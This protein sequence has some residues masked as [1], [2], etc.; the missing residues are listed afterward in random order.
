LV[1][2][3]RLEKKAIEKMALRA[4]LREVKDDVV[5][6][7][8]RAKFVNV[9]ASLCAKGAEI[10]HNLGLVVEIIKE[11]DVKGTDDAAKRVS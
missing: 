7:A 6:T 3:G 8:K 11:L 5:N 1:Q 9:L 4:K 10:H 2:L